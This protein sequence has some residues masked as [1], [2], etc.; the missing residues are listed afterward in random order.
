MADKKKANFVK[1]RAAFG[2]CGTSIGNSEKYIKHQYELLCSGVRDVRI[3]DNACVAWSQAG[4]E[5]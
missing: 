1:F 4:G 2:Q 3:A 5:W